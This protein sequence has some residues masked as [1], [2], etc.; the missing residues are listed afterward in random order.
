MVL[1][2]LSCSLLFLEP[3]PFAGNKNDFLLI[4]MSIVWSIYTADHILDG[5]KSRGQSGILRYDYHYTYRRSL[6]LILVS[7]AVFALVLIYKNRNSVFVANGMWLA[8]VL[9]FYFFLKMK[10]KLKPLVKMVIISI[11]FS[12]AVVSLYASS[13]L[14]SDF[15][16]LERLIVSIIAFIN[17]LV[18]EHFEFHEEQK[19]LQPESKDLY[20]NLADRM[21]IWTLLLLVLTTFQNMA[22]WP[23]T[24]SLLLVALFLR[25]I[26][27][28][29][30]WF[31]VNLRYRYWADFS[32]VLAW[33]FLKLLLYIQSLYL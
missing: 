2:C 32:L 16:S 26:L 15:F 22:A 11:V 24:C 3:N 14:Y 8:P 25:L 31:G 5:Y 19:P 4:L 33:P 7:V 20:L 28:F 9:P 18:L 27:R 30:K 23:F 1:G 17:L 10:G 6:S 21:F 12:A 13:S 29:Q